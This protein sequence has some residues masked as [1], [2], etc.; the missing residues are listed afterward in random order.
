MYLVHINVNSF[1]LGMYT[2]TVS[3]TVTMAV[4][5]LK[6]QLKFMGHDIKIPNFLADHSVSSSARILHSCVCIALCF[7][8]TAMAQFGEVYF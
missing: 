2:S 7:C 1:L 8:G 4:I 5:L 6:N 3:L